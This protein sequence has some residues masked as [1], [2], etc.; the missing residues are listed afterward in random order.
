MRYGRTLGCLTAALV[1]VVVCGGAAWGQEAP[2][3]RSISVSGTVETQTAPDLVVWRISLTDTDKD[4]RA[5]KTRN[6]K[7]VKDVVALRR[8]LRLDEGDLET[9]HVSI[10]REY[11]RDQQGRRGDFKHFVV[12]RDVTIRQRDLKRFDEYLDTL[13]AAGEMEL[14]FSF[15]SSRIHDVRAETRL[16]ALQAARDKAKAM[17]AVV[18]VKL[19]PVLTI[20]EHPEVN[21]SA[22][23]WSNAGFVESRPAVDLA[24]ETFVPGAITVRVTVYAT[25]ALE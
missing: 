9:G 14:S 16:K 6:D 19:G 18:G 22:S 1:G 4:L 5:A 3:E 17:A 24:T 8:K 25:F 7:R 10:R 2:R 11:E 12:S 13:V 15:E 23:P 21:R 20:N